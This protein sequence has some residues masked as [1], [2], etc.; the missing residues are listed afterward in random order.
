MGNNFSKTYIGK[1]WML[2]FLNVLILL[3][4]TMVLISTGLMACNAYAQEDPMECDVLI[5]ATDGSNNYLKGYPV[6]VKDVPCV[7]GSAEGLPDF[8]HLILTDCEASQVESFLDGWDIKYDFTIVNENELGYRL[9][10]EVDP[11]YISASDMG[12]NEIKTE[13]QD[14]ATN[15]G[16]SVV[17]FTSSSMTVDV[18]KPAN[19][20]QLKIDFN[21]AFSS[22]LDIRRYYF[23]SSDVDGVV[24]S[25]GE[26]T[27]TRTQALNNIV[28][29]LDE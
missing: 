12:K 6:A 13:M 26:M 28:D 24:S 25:G 21:D 9:R 20:L 14:W 2:H 22:V 10:A 23:S 17:N 16:F 18:P 3:L 7:W 29:K 15:L 4:V 8:I 1:V 19:T 5:R 27:L 11:I